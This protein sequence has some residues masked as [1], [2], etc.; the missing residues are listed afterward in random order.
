MGVPE[1]ESIRLLLD[2]IR[3]T[4]SD[5]SQF[6]Q[7]LKHDDDALEEETSLPP[8]DPEEGFEEL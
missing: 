3:R 6:L 1:D 2:E 5:N 7:R 4:I 8:D